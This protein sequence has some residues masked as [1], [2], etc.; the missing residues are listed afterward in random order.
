M[1]NEMVLM[2]RL[3][4]SYYDNTQFGIAATERREFGIGNVKK[5]DARHL[6]FSSEDEFRRYLRS[7]TPMFVSHSISYYDYP[8][9]TPIQMK[10][11]KGADIVFDLDIHA[12]GKYGAYAH[13]PR[14][15]QDL[16]RL[17]NDFIIGDFGIKEEHIVAAFSGNRGYH[18]HVRDPAY[19]M[20]GGEERKELVSY[21]MGQGLD[22]NA[23]FT[24]DGKKL[25]G[26]RPDEGGYR[27]RLARAT[28]QVLQQ[29][30][31]DFSKVFTDEQRRAFFISGI[32][33][34]NWSRTTLKSE[35]IVKKARVVAMG[36]PVS[37]VDTDAGVTQDLS[38]LIR[39]PNSIHGETGLIAK[40]IPLDKLHEFNP[41]VDAVIPKEAVR[42]AGLSES[43]KIKFIEDVPRIEIGTVIDATSEGKHVGP[44]K[45]DS[46]ETLSTQFAAF[47]VLK[48]S[49]NFVL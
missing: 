49:A 27:G 31:G 34:G 15:K 19:R 32:N 48:G 3:F 23:F 21:I 18:L 28:V 39:V 38:K 13:L 29:Q 14:V 30:P 42:S 33:E 7:N 24:L 1:Q 22:Y 20:L 45:K 46:E 41:W 12:D 8:G 10:K 5:I 35:D 16:I 47:F 6:N 40:T 25:L 2:K 36:L 17:L 43:M 26:P 44:F 9:A 4:A 11:W 37:S